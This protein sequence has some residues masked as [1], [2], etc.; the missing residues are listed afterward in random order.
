MQAIAYL[1][2]MTKWFHHPTR[3]PNLT[4]NVNTLPPPKLFSNA[5]AGELGRE[6]RLISSSPSFEGSPEGLVSRAKQV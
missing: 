6:R 2:T 4:S 1:L 3:E 5:A